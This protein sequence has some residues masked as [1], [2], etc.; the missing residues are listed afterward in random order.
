MFINEGLNHKIQL[1]YIQKM[2]YYVDTK[3]NVES[4]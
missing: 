4:V 3:T 1:Q 2:E